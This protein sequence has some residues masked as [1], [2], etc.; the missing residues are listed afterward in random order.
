MLLLFLIFGIALQGQS[1][2]RQVDNAGGREQ[3]SVSEAQER[4]EEQFRKR[5]EEVKEQALTLQVEYAADLLLPLIDRGVF[6]D[7][8]MEIFLL[9]HLFDSAGEA[10]QRYPQLYLGNRTNSMEAAQAATGKRSLSTLTI[11][12]SVIQRMISRD[13]AKAKQ[14]F[15]RMLLPNVPA[16]VCRDVLVP[17]LSSFYAAAK[18]IFEFGFHAESRREREDVQFL[19]EVLGRM[20]HPSLLLPALQ[21]LAEADIAAED[22]D[23]LVS[24]LSGTMNYLQADDRSLGGFNKNQMFSVAVGR[25]LDTRLSGSAGALVLGQAWREYL[26]RTTRSPVCPDGQFGFTAT[27]IGQQ[28]SGASRPPAPIAYFNEKIAVSSGVQKIDVETLRLRLS[29]NRMQET[30]IPV[31]RELYTF[32]PRLRSAQSVRGTLSASEQDAHDRTVAELL[33]GLDNLPDEDPKCPGCNFQIKSFWLSFLLQAAPAEDREE[34]ARRRLALLSATTTQR[35]YPE[36]WLRSLDSAFGQTFGR[37][38]SGN[39]TGATQQAD[40]RDLLLEAWLASNDPLLSVYAKAE[41]V[42]PRFGLG[43]RLA[44]MYQREPGTDSR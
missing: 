11:Q 8:G 27:G 36:L 38:S 20:N 44:E 33:R 41:A 25:L 4:T 34:L 21:H 16:T 19:N 31:S 35:Q 18:L 39:P 10:V 32:L 30:E 37:S 17:D 7:I 2:P 6:D 15:S 3:E 22:L 12:S 42:A 23:M 40:P 24:T 5:V 14:Q 29:E 1:E 26:L 9:D 13:P 43:R 28:V